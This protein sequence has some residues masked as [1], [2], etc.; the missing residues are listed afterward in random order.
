MVDIAVF[1]RLRHTVIAL[2]GAAEAGDWDRFL[3]LQ[4]DY[5][6]AVTDLPAPDSVAIAE[7]ERVELNSVLR[8]V[9]AGLDVVLPLAQAHKAQLAEELAGARKASK[10]NRTYS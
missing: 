7:S 9:Q 3:L 6:R 8:Q 2:Q 4:Q 5:L 10:L 1:H